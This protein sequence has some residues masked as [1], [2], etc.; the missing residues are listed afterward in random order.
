MA[1]C[2]NSSRILFSPNPYIRSI[3]HP[4]YLLGVLLL[5]L[6][7]HGGE[8]GVAEEL[9]VDLWGETGEK[10]RRGEV[11]ARSEEIEIESGDSGEL[12]G[13]GGGKGVEYA[14]EGHEPRAGASA[15]GNPKATG[16]VARRYGG[17]RGRDDTPGGFAHLSSLA[18]R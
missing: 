12:V 7:L 8:T 10:R 15:S 16:G 2:E 13:G 17:R 18:A 5:A 3:E 14:P 6:V 4:V 1:V 9:R 11:G